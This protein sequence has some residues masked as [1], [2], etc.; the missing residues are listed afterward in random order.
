MPHLKNERNELKISALRDLMRDLHTF[1][2]GRSWDEDV[3][4]I[5]SAAPDL[6]LGVQ[7]LYGPSADLVML[8]KAR[9]GATFLGT[10]FVA[11]SGFLA[12]DAEFLGRIIS[13]EE[14]DG[15]LILV[16]GDEEECYAIYSG[17]SG[18][19]HATMF[20]RGERVPLDMEALTSGREKLF[21]LGGVE[22]KQFVEGLAEA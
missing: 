8:L 19:R 15:Y 1:P 5:E 14:M 4:R 10:P 21:N 16:S 20:R 3:E 2:L 12:D 18:G 17:L 13:R 9:P 11:A 7:R 6:L 22:S